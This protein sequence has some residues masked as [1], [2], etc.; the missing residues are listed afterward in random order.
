MEIRFLLHAVI[1][2]KGMPQR[3]TTNWRFLV[4]YAIIFSK[5]FNQSNKIY[6][7]FV[8]ENHYSGSNSSKKTD[9]RFFKITF[10]VVC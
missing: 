2:R 4:F 9:I 8:T 6:L 7:N 10:K 3:S 1:K 5:S